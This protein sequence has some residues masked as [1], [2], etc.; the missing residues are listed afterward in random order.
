MDFTPNLSWTFSDP[1]NGD[2]QSACRVIVADSQAA[3]D[4]N[5]GN[6]CDTGKILCSTTNVA[7]SGAYLQENMQYFWKV[8]TWDNLDS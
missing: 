3:L 6:V 5:N 4:G 1:D 7:Y 8:M 2:T